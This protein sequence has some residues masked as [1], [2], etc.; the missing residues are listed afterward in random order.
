VLS[1]ECILIVE[2]RN[3]ASILAT[4]STAPLTA[5]LLIGAGGGRARS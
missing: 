5:T 4:S 2:A 1:G 3:V